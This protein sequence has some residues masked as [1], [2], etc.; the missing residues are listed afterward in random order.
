M[1]VNIPTHYVQEYSSNI[2]LLLQQRGSKLRDAVMQGS[3]VGKQASPVDQVGAIAMQPVSGRFNAMGRVDA[4][5]DRRW[6]LPSDFDLPQLI[7]SFDKLRLLTD[8]ESTYVTNAVMAAGRQM[9]DLI[10]DAFFGD[11]NT[12][13]T[14]SG[15]TSH[16]SSQQV[17]V[18]FGSSSNVGLTVAKLREAKKILMANEVDLEADPLTCVVTA[19][20]HDNLLAEAQVIS[21]DYN[22]KPVL[23]DGRI[24]SFLGINFIHCERLD[25]DGSSFR[26]VPIFA[27]SGMHLGLW[28]DITTDISQ[29][30][31]LQGL[32]FQAYVYMTAGATRLEEKKIVE[33][34]CAE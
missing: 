31:D 6:V 18:N 34:K 24:N 7:D 12:G 29:R 14:G 11:A 3:H 1:S 8:P 26:R 13:E 28:N 30:K 19:K 25:L 2:E 16:P 4:P 9:D 21:L 10:I 20:Q 22:D 27:K 15:T 23:V 5:T 17:A 32:P 33:V